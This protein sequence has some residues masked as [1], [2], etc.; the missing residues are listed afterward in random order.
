[1][2]LLTVYQVPG[3]FSRA[4]TEQRAVKNS[5]GSLFK[6][7]KNRKARYESLSHPGYAKAS[8]NFFPTGSSVFQ[9]AMQQYMVARK[10]EKIDVFRQD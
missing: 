1:M 2:T 3:F 7:D 8:V 10:I 5:R 6:L 4:A 9:L